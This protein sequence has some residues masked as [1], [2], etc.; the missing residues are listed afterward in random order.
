LAFSI[1]GRLAAKASNQLQSNLKNWYGAY[2]IKNYNTLR[3]NYRCFVYTFLEKSDIPQGG[4]LAGLQVWALHV[5]LSGCD[6]L[7]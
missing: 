7:P 1:F 6:V 2:P 4:I 3:E 5:K